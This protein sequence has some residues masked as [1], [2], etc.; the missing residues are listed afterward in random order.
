[1]AI[2]I[3]ETAKISLP[4]TPHSAGT[5]VCVLPDVRSKLKLI[6]IGRLLGFDLHPELEELHATVIYSRGHLPH[7]DQT[8]PLIE[9]EATITGLEFWPGHDKEGYIVA[10]LNSPDLCALHQKW[11]DRGLR[12]SFEDYEP[13]VTLVKDCGTA[14]L[15][16]QAL[17]LLHSSKI[18]GSRLTFRSEMVEGLKDN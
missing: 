18:V 15:E 9:H 10:K 7:D 11:L 3:L 2:R 14:S 13:H 16:V 12:H 5:Y 4:L 8:S 17:M 1:M 6:Q